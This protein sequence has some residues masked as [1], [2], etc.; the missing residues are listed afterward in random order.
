MKY[1]MDDTVLYR[2]VQIVQEAILMGLECG[3]CLRQIEMTPAENDPGKLVLTS[4]YKS[5]VAKMHEEW[6]KKA[7]E[8]K[9]SEC[10]TEECASCPHSCGSKII[11]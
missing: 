2:I 5:N 11:S 6:L 10:S 1:K 7:E 3:D 9:A 4:E 8:L